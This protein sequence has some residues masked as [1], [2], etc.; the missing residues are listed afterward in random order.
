LRT[1]RRPNGTELNV[2]MPANFGQLSDPELK[3]IWSYLKTLPPKATG[4]R[5]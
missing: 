2:V 5:E 4:Q 3:A 1:R